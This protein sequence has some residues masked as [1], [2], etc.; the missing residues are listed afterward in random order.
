MLLVSPGDRETIRQKFWRNSQKFFVSR[1]KT[2]RHRKKTGENANLLPPIGAGCAFCPPWAIRSAV[3]SRRGFV[4]AGNTFFTQPRK[5][6][7]PENPCG[8]LTVFHILHSF[9]HSR[10]S[11]IPQACGEIQNVYIKYLQID[12]KF[13]TFSENGQF[14]TAARFVENY[15]LDKGTSRMPDP[16]EAG[17]LP[18]LSS[19]KIFKKGLIL[20]RF[21][22]IIQHC[23]K[24]CCEEV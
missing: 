1:R 5:P 17:V 20:L 11:T 3:F 23:M 4:N 8:K 24:Y 16:G 9:F 14:A 10:F 21:S 19:R 18:F 15:P 7:P 6:A 13:F 2:G 12:T 22:A